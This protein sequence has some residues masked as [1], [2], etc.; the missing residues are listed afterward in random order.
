MS[1]SK[2]TRLHPTRSAVLI[3]V[4]GLL[5]LYNSL[6]LMIPVV[7]T[8]S[9]LKSS[10]L[11]LKIVLIIMMKKMLRK[12]VSPLGRALRKTLARKPGVTLL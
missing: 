2:K 1:S 9:N 4:N 12:T 7:V 6:R 10:K 5:I 3:N 8:I 11:I